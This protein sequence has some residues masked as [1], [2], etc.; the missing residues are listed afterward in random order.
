MHGSIELFRQIQC[1]FFSAQEAQN[2][3]VYSIFK[4]ISVLFLAGYKKIKIKIE[5]GGGGGR[6]VKSIFALIDVDSLLK[7][8]LGMRSWKWGMFIGCL[9]ASV[10]PVQADLVAHWDFGITNVVDGVLLSGNGE[11]Q[12]INGDGVLSA[13]DFL[14][15]AADLS[16]NGNHLTAW[17]SS[18]MKWTKHRFMSGYSIKNAGSE[19][20]LCTDSTY[21]PF[22]TGIDAES[23]SPAQWTIE[24]VFRS[25]N[26]GEYCT[27]VG[28]NGTKI[29]NTDRE[30]APLYFSTRGTDLAIQ[31]NDVDG[32]VHTLQVAAG[33]KKDTWYSA[34]AVSDGSTLSLY[35]NGEVI[36]TL[37]LTT[38]G[39]DTALA[40]GFGTWTVAC[41]MW[42]ENT[43]DYFSGTINEVAISD[44]ALT[45]ET[46]VIALPVVCIDA[47]GDGMSDLYETFFALNETNSASLNLDADTLVNWMEAARWTDP[48]I[49]DTDMD[50]IDDDQ[51][52][53]PLSRAVMIWGHAGFSQN[54]TYNYTGPGWWVG[55]GKSGGSWS[56][57]GP[58]WTVDAE[59]H[60]LLYMDI[61]RKLIQS[62]L[63]LELLHE[64][65]AGCR[66][67]LDLGNNRGTYAVT[68]LFG[69]LIL[70]DGDQ[71]LDR[72][73]LP[74]ETYPTATR[75]IIDAYA[76][77]NPYK[78][79][80]ASLY[81]DCDADGLD[82]EQEIQF[83]TS[84]ENV[85][86][87]GDGLSDMTEALI[88]HTDP[89]NPD[90]D[91]DGI[92]D[93][94]EINTLETSPLIPIWK[95]GGMPSY[96][97]GER[98]NEIWQG[99][100]SG[101]INDGRF[102]G[103]PDLGFLVS[104]S[105]YAANMY[106]DGDHF[107]IRLRGTFRAPLTGSYTFTL[108]GDDAAQVWLS[109]S[110]SPYGRKLLLD[111]QDPVG[112]QEITNAI[113]PTATIE[114]VADQTY[115]VEIL[116]QE[117]QSSEHVS[118]F[119]T[120][121]GAPEPKLIGPQY[122]HSYVQ[123]EDDPDGDG[124]PSAWEIAN[125]FDPE[126]GI[127][128]GYR[129]SDGNGVCDIDQCRDELPEGAA[130]VDL[131]NDGLL[132]WW[133]VQYGISGAENDA[134]NDGLSNLEEYRWETDPLTAD[135]D[136]DGV[137]DGQEVTEK[138]DPINSD[139][140]NDGINDG[141]EPV[142]GTD[143][144]NPDTDHDGLLD[145]EELEMGFSPLISVWQQGGMSGVLQ[146][147]RWNNMFGDR[148]ETLVSAADRYGISPDQFYLTDRTDYAANS[149]Q[150][151]GESY[152]TR[153]RGTIT[154]PVSGDYTFALTGDDLAQVWLSNSESP[155]GRER[156]LDLLDWSKYQELTDP[157]V[158][159]AVVTLTAGQAY[160][161]EILHK[162]DG[163][164]EHV[165]L[166]WTVPGERIPKI[167][168]SEYL[169]S[170]VQP[171][172]D[173][174]AD[175]LPDAWE[176]A[177]GL[178]PTNGVGGGMA[179][180]DGDGYFDVEEYALGLSPVI[181]DGDSDGL[182]SGDELAITGT[183]PFSADS[184]GDGIPDLT[185]VLY[186][187]GPHFTETADADGS[188]WSS[189][190]TD[191]IVSQAHSSPWIS[192]TL[193]VEEAGM[194][195]LAIDATYLRN[196]EGVAQEVRFAVSIDGIQFDGVWMNHSD[197]LP[198]YTFY[199][200]WLTEGEH[201]LKLTVKC[202][203]WVNSAF[204]I[205]GIA[206]DTVDGADADAN[207]LQDWVEARIG[208][209]DT[210]S[211]GIK[212]LD[213]LLLGS[214]PLNAD[215]DDDGLCDGDEALITQTDMF[216]A[217]TDQDGIADL[218]TV[219]TVPGADFTSFDSFHITAEW[220]TDG[221]NATVSEVHVNPWIS[222]TLS[223]EEAG[224]YH[225]GINAAYLQEDERIAR[226]VWL[227]VVIDGIYL[228][229]VYET[230]SSAL[231]PF[232]FCTP[233]LSQGEH[234]LKLIVRTS[235]WSAAPFT[236]YN[237]E[238]GTIDG[239]DADG[240]GIQDWMDAQMGGDVDTDGDGILD[241]DELAMGTDLLNADTDGD[242]LNDGAELENRTDPL[243][244][245]TDNDGVVDGVEVKESM[246]DPL[247]AEFDG[248][249]TAVLT[250]PGAQTNSAAG[251]WEV[252][253]DEILSIGRR[254]Y[255][256]YV[257]DFPEQDL[258]CL[259]VNAAHQWNFYSSAPEEPLDTSAFLVYVDDVFVGEYTFV[260][261]D[262]VYED[263]RAFLPVLPAGEHT[264]HLFWENVHTRIAVQ[265]HDLQLQSLGGPDVNGNGMKDWVEVSIAA[266]AGVD[267]V[268]QASL[269][270]ESY[271]SP[272]C[273]EGD[274][275]YVPFMEIVDGASCS[276]PVA[277][278]AGERWFANL[279]LEE[280]GTTEAT[281]TFQNGALEVPFSLD[282]VPY[283]LI[284]HNGETLT[285]RKGDRVKLEA[286]PA[287]ANGGQFTLTLSGADKIISEGNRA[288]PGSSYRSPNTHPLIFEFPE[289][290]TYV[291]DGDYR[292]GNTHT[293]AS[294]TVEVYDGTF[295]EE[296]PACLLGKQ[297]DWTFDGMPTNVVYEVDD[298]VM[299][300][301]ATSSSREEESDGDVASTTLSLT[302][303][304]A[305][306][307]HV[308][309][310]RLCPGGPI[311]DSVRLDT[312]WIQVAADGYFWVVDKF[313]D[314]EL[315]EVES[316][317]RNLP[318]TVDLQIKVYVGGVV[319]DDYT[320]ERWITNADY[321]EIGI[322]RFRLFHPNDAETSVCH[323]FKAYQDGEF[324]GEMLLAE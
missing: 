305:N 79:W 149:A 131:D 146:V 232:T 217:D 68:N 300:V 10:S 263:V 33:L 259:N 239:K 24:V 109:D 289:A 53:D 272:A 22:I 243:N 301:D 246:T 185:R 195:R 194:Y 34:A 312:C 88:K 156:I 17:N 288:K 227:G 211:D 292:K 47:D 236:I 11:R 142:Q 209:A 189:D 282:W 122:L 158:P 296:S 9:L 138:T 66:V 235:F 84:D 218:T 93:G 248:T 96:L 87:D 26:L 70:G 31:Y 121:P 169:H 172:D 58:C 224:M 18:T 141:E 214:D 15:G 165:S 206:L 48:R 51:D 221:T 220:S 102:G 164:R 106:D 41:G 90:S 140:D 136:S 180:T 123:P 200:P 163:D 258:Y 295:P 12:D 266:M 291:I 80:M 231:L 72:Y 242:G 56:T 251:D 175:G 290:G 208:D 42:G 135:S 118:L 250:V 278:S 4:H 268:G 73:V 271:I 244:P 129:D 6:Y 97:Q 94:K 57:N 279:P 23:I 126:N 74:L 293:Y 21:N 124:L 226:R 294:I 237:I 196:Y 304:E 107:G 324:L 275:R 166:F 287:N 321:D 161:V 148:I 145:G 198:T 37:D 105:Q 16:G 315:W 13:D 190:E 177:N 108:T 178:N 205:H 29:G 238:L 143:P 157:D 322:Y 49:T 36:G 95:E 3:F 112:Y 254:G 306:R 162:E 113:V 132:D 111:L 286:L 38:S 125:E 110:D 89:S 317:Q 2:P 228:G 27:I 117:Y 86:S 284:D 216:S 43:V 120:L 303:H 262:G 319:F 215:M 298:T 67:Y 187:L 154:A 308:M 270:V 32:V 240:N 69:N 127:G 234:T 65:V 274:A 46:F 54:N 30:L 233:W 39:T 60:G 276:V 204:Q 170:Y 264:V 222:Y 280:N 76:G 59:E 281:A 159:S 249:V 255:V 247:I 55:A 61:D 316:I 311:V 318:D 5:N 273:I 150:D 91:R 62:D 40:E 20:K 207:G 253:E 323:T 230:S 83:G 313:E 35:L 99:E 283:N 285:I 223:V 171:A 188:T 78:V 44:E 252:I 174:D 103:R 225:L 14:I 181:A 116:M 219:L 28:R 52:N 133:A 212:D 104:S 173:M 160:Y 302:A 8:V 64:D 245:D 167:I 257:L 71:V 114:L 147:E 192:Y 309:L 45:P 193:P 119:W 101:L 260:S 85:D 320:L 265:I 81:V 176:I 115:Y 183:D 201:L 256:E 261:T 128:G 151:G 182:S 202:D 210:D 82:T 77:A 153:M 277:Q 130:H 92:A 213:E 7:G 184:D 199:T 134:D 152:G 1:M 19:P 197:D 299:L 297:R 25:D 179:D 310:A 100:V 267:N 307:E 98:W 168:T 314:S 50:G 155:Y 203:Y 63:M 144:L 75:I 269:P 229:E 191:A 139:T 241:R 137:M 186:V